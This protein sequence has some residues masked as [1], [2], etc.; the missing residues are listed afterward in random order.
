MI[1]RDLDSFCKS[2]QGDRQHVDE[3][4]GPDKSSPGGGFYSTMT[5]RRGGEHLSRSDRRSSI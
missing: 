2:N 1:A 3:K 4:K 5:Y